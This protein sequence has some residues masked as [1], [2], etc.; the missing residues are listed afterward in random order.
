MLQILPHDD[1]SLSSAARSHIKNLLFDSFN[2][3][4]SEA[5]W[6]HSCGG[7][8]VL[9]YLDGELI[10]HGAIVPR[11]FIVDGQ[12]VLVG[13]VEGVAVKPSYRRK[14]FGSL[15][16]AEVTA[17]S[18][19]SYMISMLSTGEKHF[20]RKQGWLDFLGESFVLT[21]GKKLRSEEED[22]G[23][24]YVLRQDSKFKSVTTVV[25][26]ARIGDSW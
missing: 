19:A 2:G 12:N 14:G 21:G 4:F 17:L 26:E 22:N 9:G 10:A 16:L 25:C 7:I 5:D 11:R 20:Y 18:R 13:Y 23:L 24:M 6:Q 15:V 1:Q 3:E 8:R